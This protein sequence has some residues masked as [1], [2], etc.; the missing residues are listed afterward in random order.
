MDQLNFA[1]VILSDYK[2][3]K[4]IQADYK[5]EKRTTYVYTAFY[6]TLLLS[7]I[8]CVTYN[9]PKLSKE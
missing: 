4:L 8:K 6:C 2:A 7:Y 3:G 9:W 5:A 1:K